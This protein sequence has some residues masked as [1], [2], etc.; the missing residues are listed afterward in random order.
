MDSVGRQHCPVCNAA[1]RSQAT[2]SRCGAD[3]AVLMKLSM[4]AR[5]LRERARAAMR[6][7]DTAS[8]RGCLDRAEQLHATPAGHRLAMLLKWMEP[9]NARETTLGR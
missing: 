6:R 8:A 5:D 3:L 2:C 7:G 1:F 4:A 9:T